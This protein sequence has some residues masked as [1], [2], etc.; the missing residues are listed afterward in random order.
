MF[1]CAKCN[2]EIEKV[3]SIKINEQEIALICPFCD[4]RIMVE[5][6]QEGKIIKA[7]L[8]ILEG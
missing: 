6:T 7:P 8:K 1:K 3:K 4:N 5:Q 2:Q